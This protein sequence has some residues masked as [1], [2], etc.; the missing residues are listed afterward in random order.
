MSRLE[1]DIQLQVMLDELVVCEDTGE[2]ASLVSAPSLT[3]IGAVL[4][5]EYSR[6]VTHLVASLL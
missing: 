1:R 6:C 5:L 2:L 3:T 4:W